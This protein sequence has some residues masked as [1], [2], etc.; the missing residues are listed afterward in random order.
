LTASSQYTEAQLLELSNELPSGPRLLAEINGMLRDPSTDN[1]EIISVLRRDPAL[2]ARLLR[3]ANSAVFARPEPIGAVEEAVMA[4]GFAEVHRV[5]GA[6]A[7]TQLADRPLRLHGI[8]GTRFRENALFTACLTQHLAQ[9]SGLDPQSFYTAGMLRTLGIIVLEQQVARSPRIIPPFKSSGEADLFTWQ[10]RHWGLD[11]SFVTARILRHWNMP[12]E[13]AA[14]VECHLL[15]SNFPA[16][17]AALLRLAALITHREG[18]GLGGEVLGIEDQA[19]VDADL[20][21][22]AL[23]AAVERAKLDFHAMHHSVL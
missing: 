3:V 21:P 23:D 20:S 11:S 6:M 5:V 7:A 9:V 18:Y 19:R 14:A 13:L 12:G 10:R 1:D 15:S 17:E 4:I 16:R 2:V 22:E 8:S